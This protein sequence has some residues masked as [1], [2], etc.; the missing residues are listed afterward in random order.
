[1]TKVRQAKPLVYIYI[2]R[3]F[4]FYVIMSLGGVCF[5]RGVFYRDRQT[6]PDRRYGLRN[7]INSQTIVLFAKKCLIYGIWHP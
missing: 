3:D 5:S 1:M 4:F 2:K 7:D 6:G